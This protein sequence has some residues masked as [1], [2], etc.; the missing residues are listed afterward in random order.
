VLLLVLSLVSG[1]PGVLE[2]PSSTVQATVGILVV[3]AGIAMLVPPV[4][5]WVAA[6]TVPVWRQTWP[7]LVQLLGQPK[8]FAVAVA[9]NLLMTL[10]YLGAFYACLAAFGREDL[11]LVDLALIYLVGNAAGAAVPT[12]GGL[13]TVEAALIL[14]LTTTG[15]IPGAIATSVVVLFRGLTFWGRIPFGWAAM[16]TLQRSNE[17]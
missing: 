13:G 3:L 10:G 16:R 4:R 7:R 11:T 1:T 14:G 17:L 12:P 9:G 2:L 6:K 5:Q 8:R 15:G